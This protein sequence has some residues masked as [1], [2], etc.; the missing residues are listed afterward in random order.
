MTL[1]ELLE[2]KRAMSLN[3]SKALIRRWAELAFG[4]DKIDGL[5]EVLSPT[6]RVSIDR[7]KASWRELHEK[8]PDIVATVE[9]QIAEGD[10]VMTRLAISATYRGKPTNWMA[11]YIH[12]IR[13]GKIRDV[14]Q[15]SDGPQ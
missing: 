10:K 13:D 6:H 3:E 2:Y 4:R 14:W 11:I 15:L 9:D 8:F 12:E 1:G 7:V 5:S